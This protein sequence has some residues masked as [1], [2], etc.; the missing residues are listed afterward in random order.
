MRRLKKAKDHYK[1]TGVVK[2][3]TNDS[4]NNQTQNKQPV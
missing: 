3:V 4:Y 2:L 1:S